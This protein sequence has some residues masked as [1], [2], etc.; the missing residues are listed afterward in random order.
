MIDFKKI[1]CYNKYVI[2]LEHLTTKNHKKKGCES[3]VK[4]KTA[5]AKKIVELLAKEQDFICADA[6][7]EK[8]SNELS[9]VDIKKG[10]SCSSSLSMATLSEIIEKEQIAYNKKMLQHY[11]LKPNYQE[12]IEKEEN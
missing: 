5:K 10:K 7:Y 6:F 4:L 9:Q 12:L 8:Y 11:K 3:M 2:K 1:K